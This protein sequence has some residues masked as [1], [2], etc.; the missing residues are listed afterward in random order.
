[1]DTTVS[2][3]LRTTFRCTHC[4]IEETINTGVLP[5][6]NTE[7]F[8]SRRNNPASSTTVQVDEV[9]FTFESADEQTTE[10]SYYTSDG[11]RG[12][13]TVH[14]LHIHT[15]DSPTISEGE[16]QVMLDDYINEKMYL[17]TT[18][19]HKNGYR[20]FK[21]YRPMHDDVTEPLDTIGLAS[22]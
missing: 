3:D 13:S 9:E 10:N 20:T 14:H 19:Y 22:D 2:E 6:R 18:R 11:I 8:E 17:S 12:T 15:R 21:F 7:F 1:M 4:N 16:H 5:E